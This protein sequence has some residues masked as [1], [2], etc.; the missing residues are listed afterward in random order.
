[1]GEQRAGDK[2]WDMEAVY[3]TEISPLMA[4][5]IAICKRVKMPFVA[6]FHYQNAP[7]EDDSGEALCTSGL[8]VAERPSPT[9]AAATSLIRRHGRPP[10]LML[11]T[12]GG[13]GKVKAMEAILP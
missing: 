12:I 1:M 10:A 5:I 13:D 2:T 3:D 8:T 4:E 9:I 11:T 6:S 7:H